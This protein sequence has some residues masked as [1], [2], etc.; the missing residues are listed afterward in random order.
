MK[1]PLPQLATHLA[2]LNL[3]RNPDGTLN[4]TVAEGRG[5]ISELDVQGKLGATIPHDYILALV[6]SALAPRYVEACERL[7]DVLK[8]DDGEAFFEAEKFLKGNVPE[9]YN[10]L[11]R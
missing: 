11:G 4:V 6:K 1:R 10:K 8:Q 5:A 2:T 9:L 7:L 3:F